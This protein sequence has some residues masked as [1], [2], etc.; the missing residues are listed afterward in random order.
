MKEKASETLANARRGE[1]REAHNF[2]MMAQ[3]L[4][5]AIKINQ[6][7]TSQA[8]HSISTAQQENGKAKNELSLTKQ[9]MAA[10]QAYLASLTRDCNSARSNWEERQASGAGEIAAIEK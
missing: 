5:D 1:Q 6:E 8:K 4:H 9:T 3:S 2:Q 10:D 7:K